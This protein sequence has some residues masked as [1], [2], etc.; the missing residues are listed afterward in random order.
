MKKDELCYWC[1]KLATSREHVPPKSLFPENKDIKMI[2][3]N[4]YRNNLITVPS[5]DEHNMSK[6][7]DDEYLMACL[8]GRVGNNGIAYIHN[9][10]KVKRARERNPSIIQIYKDDVI[11]IRNKEYPVQL[12]IID[13]LRLIHSF[14]AIARA[15]YYYDKGISFNGECN[16]VSDIFINPEDNRSTSFLNRAIKLIEDELPY[17]GTEVMGDNADIFTYQFSPIDGFKCQ[18]L[19]LTFYKTLKVYV[20]LAEMT[21]DEIE[22]TKVK[23]EFINKIIF[24]DL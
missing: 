24:G 17:W 12:A 1:G 11:K 13:N 19:A 6:S 22:K 15:L 8:S 23:F 7:N 16:F 5:C 9:S 3:N 10:T 4:S 18:T 14:E 21:R 2:S 20:I